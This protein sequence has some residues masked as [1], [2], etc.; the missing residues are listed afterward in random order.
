[1]RNAMLFFTIIVTMLVAGYA[2]A[3]THTLQPGGADSQDSY[4]RSDQPDTNYGGAYDL[5]LGFNTGRTYYSYIR[6]DDLDDYLD[7]TINSAE[8][9]LYVFYVSGTIVDNNYVDVPSDTWDEDTITYNNAPAPAYAYTIGYSPPAENSW[10]SVDVTTIV[11][12]WA[13]GTR[14]HYGFYLSNG[15]PSNGE[16][17]SIWSAE[18]P[19]DLDPYLVIDY[20][21]AV[22][23]ASLGNIKAA[24]K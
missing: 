6:F 10:F 5:N 3:A 9:N 21:T 20:T 11:Q 17:Y 22:E 2:V 18:G 24:F 1:M 13:A 19:N 8:L 7:E 15:G 4:I 16:F 23:S 12:D 14:D